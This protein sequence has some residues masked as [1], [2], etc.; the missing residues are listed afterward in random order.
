MK[1]DLRAALSGYRAVKGR[2]DLLTLPPRRFLMVD[3]HGDPNVSEEYTQA[4][5]ALYPV[6]YALKFLSARELGHDYT[7]PP[8]EGLWWADDHGVFTTHRD[9]AQWSWTMMILVPEWLTDE[10][11]DTARER[12][13]AKGVAAAI[14][15]TASLDEGMIIQTLHIG[16]FDDEGPV[17]VEMHNAVIPDRG[18]EMTGVHHEIYLSDPRRAAPERLRTILR[19]PVRAVARDDP[20]G[21]TGVAA[22]AR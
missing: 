10:H 12:A 17:L 6:A 13:E 9:K 14:V 22:P 19:Q 7:V 8:L 3:G 4:L 11:I 15:R 5:A 21:S 1:T 16:P 20:D 18:L 2:F